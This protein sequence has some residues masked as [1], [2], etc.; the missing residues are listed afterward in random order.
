MSYPAYNSYAKAKTDWIGDIPSHWEEWKVNHGFGWIGSGTTPKSDNSLYYGGDTLWVTTA[1]LR[2]EFIYETATNVTQDA[3]DEHSALKK[4]PVGSVVIAMYGATIGR[5]GMLG[6]EATVNQACCVFS[7]PE[8][9]HPRFYYYWLWMRRPILISL[10]SGGGQPNLNQEEL[11]RLRVPIPNIPEQ[12]QIAAFLDWK[13]GQIEALI[14]KKKELLETL[15]EKRIAVI[16][17]AVTQG[18]NP[19]APMRD[20]GIPSLGQIPQHWRVKRLR[21]ACSRIEQGWSPQCDNQPADEDSWGV[22]KVGCVNRDLFDPEENKRLPSEL[23]PA[24]E[25]ELKAGDILISRA[26]TSELLG[27]AALVPAGT[28]GKLLLCDKLFRVSPETEIRNDFLTF[29]L[30]TPIARF[31]Y[32]REA[33]GASSSMKN[34][35]QDTIKDLPTTI[36]PLHEQAAICDFIRERTGKLD[37]LVAAVETAIARL[38]EYRT[39]LI[40]AAT[41]G[42]IDVRKVKIPQAAT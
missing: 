13:T 27:S 10:S 5:L 11:K 23:E 21:F 14:A 40:T 31:Q 1:E 6:K 26:N 7:A 9:F 22:M 8:R 24:L 29:F 32:E 2:E 25:Y 41:T 3:L 28:R 37:S 20:S 16:T 30:R 33:T 35:G 4:Y 39:A 18:L 42:K 19:A 15:K 38:A 12:Q 34:I 36:P 17:Q